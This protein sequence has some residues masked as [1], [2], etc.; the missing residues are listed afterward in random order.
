MPN[1]CNNSIAFYQADG[2]NDML[3]AFYADIKKCRDYKDPATGKSSDWIGYWLESNRVDTDTIY[4]RGFLSWCE[5]YSNYVHVDMET[6]WAPLPEV[7][8]IMAKKY[9]LSYVYIA[10]E[11]GSEI[12][13]NTDSEGRFFATRYMINSFDVECLG[14]DSE[15]EEKFG[16][17]LREIGTDTTYYDSFA[18]VLDKFEG[19]GF[20]VPDLESLNKCLEVFNIEVYEYS[21]TQ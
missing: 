18:E 7:Y 15:A 13:V 19:F 3:D 16:E 5:M 4:S 17:R 11:P 1:W 20:N 8:S 21:H 6:A 14:L 10:E 9:N 2:G 12:Y